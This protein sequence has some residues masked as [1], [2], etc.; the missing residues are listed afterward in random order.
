MN[1]GQVRAA[2][3]HN[4]QEIETAHSRHVDVGDQQDGRL[5][6]MA[7]KDVQRGLA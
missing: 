6:N 2:R 4:R 5:F 1:T 3:F 7:V